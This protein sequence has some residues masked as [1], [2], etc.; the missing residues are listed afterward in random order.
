MKRC[1]R[2]VHFVMLSGIKNE[3]YRNRKH[4]LY[5]RYRSQSRGNLCSI[6][7]WNHQW[8]FCVSVRHYTFY[9]S[10]GISDQYWSQ[11]K[12]RLFD[13]TFNW[14]AFIQEKYWVYCAVRAEYLNMIQ[15][16]NIELF[17]GTVF[18]NNQN[19]ICV[20]FQFILKLRSSL[21]AVRPLNPHRISP[22]FQNSVKYFS[23]S[24]WRAC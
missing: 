7:P 1:R 22:H 24:G 12:H 8:L 21:K 13:Y 4:Q 15:V 16:D 2:Y 10:S 18:K 3:Y 6:N 17:I 14:L 20:K 19:T 11:N 23:P 9:T 5:L